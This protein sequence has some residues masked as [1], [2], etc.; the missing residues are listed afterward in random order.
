MV[1]GL[2]VAQVL[3]GSIPLGRP[4]FVPVPKWQGRRLQPVG[5]EFDSPPV[6]HSL[7]RQGR[8]VAHNLTRPKDRGQP[9]WN[10]G[11]EMGV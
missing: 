11:R 6:L 5:Q 9:S 2:L 7:K 3:G 8:R 4:I 1:R 10:R